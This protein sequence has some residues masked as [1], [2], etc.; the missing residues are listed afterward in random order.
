M[1]MRG[2]LPGQL[3]ARS[4]RA[5]TRRRERRLVVEQLAERRRQRLDV[6]GRDDAAGAERPHGLAEAADV[7]DDRRHAGA[8]RPQQRAAL[9]ELGAVREDGDGRL[10]ERPVDLGLGEEGV[11]VAGDAERAPG[12]RETA[13]RACS[14]CL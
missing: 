11:G 6:V 5:G 3:L 13:S 4:Q 10:A 9:V 12:T 2:R 1:G 7:V 8:E 14:S